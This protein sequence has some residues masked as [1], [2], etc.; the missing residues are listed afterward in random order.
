MIRWLMLL[1]LLPLLGCEGD[2]LRWVEGSALRA[3]ESESE[4]GNDLDLVIFDNAGICAASNVPDSLI[5][6]CVP[7][8][9]RSRG[10]VRLGFQFRLGGETFALPVNEDNL[11]VFHMDAQVRDGKDYGRVEVIP[12]DPERASQLFILVIDGSGSM[13]ETDSEGV[14]RMEKVRKA[15]LRR[16]VVERF[17]PDDADVPTGVVLLTFTQ[18]TP[19]PVGTSEIEVITEPKRYRELIKNHLRSSGGYTHLYDAIGYATG[20]L[21]QVEVV[22]D[23]YLNREAEPTIIALTDG[24]NNERSD[25]TCGTNAE[26]LG[27]LLKRLREARE[28]DQISLRVRPSVYTVGL[29][30]ILRRR[31]SILEN[32]SSKS[33]NVTPR[34]LCGKKLEN[35]RI[36]GDLETRG[37]DNASLEWIAAYGGGFAYVRRSSEGLGEAF[38][39]A[40]AERYRW[41][42]LRYALDPFYLRRSFKSTIRLTTFARAEGSIV[43][44]PSAWFDAPTPRVDADGW[45]EPVPFRSSLGL[46]MPLLGGLV[47]LSFVGAAGFNAKRVVFGRMRRPRRRKG[48]GAGDGTPGGTPSG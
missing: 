34:Q 48:A 30:R 3:E 13:N 38:K 43:L 10:Q 23:F 2:G 39:A 11:E 35:W 16:D 8:V 29:G 40:A 32:L 6:R 26:R 9:D 41:F 22:K 20:E 5:S 47:T 31:S 19:R 33:T 24:F 28:N 27:R 17:F 12:H 44:H 36:D 4:R 14:S 25:D 18:G 45:S 15:L 46:L 37:I 42:E 7:G 21:L 1:L